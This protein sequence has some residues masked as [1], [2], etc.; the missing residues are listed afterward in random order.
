VLDTRNYFLYK[1]L[2]GAIL[3]FLVARSF[4]SKVAA[5]PV[6]AQS[7]DTLAGTML[8]GRV[9]GADGKPLEGV[10]VSAR[11]VE[12]TFTTSVFTDAQGNYFFPVLDQGKYRVWVQAVGFETARVEL[13]LDPAKQ[14]R[15]NFALKTRDDLT[16]QLSGAE[17]VDALPGDT[18]EN[19]RMKEI[20][21]H[22]CGN[23]HTPSFP[24]Q[25][26]FDRAGWLKILTA[27]ETANAGVGGWAEKPRP[28]I[29][30]FK[31]ELASYLAKMRGPDPSPMQFHPLP[32]P[33][34]DA[35]RVVMTEYDIPPAETPDRLAVLDGSDWA[36]GTP[37][38]FR[39]RGTHDVTEDFDGNAW[40]TSTAPNH[41]RTYGKIDT[42]TGK[43]TN[44][45]VDFKQDWVRWSH[46]IETAPDGMI[47]ITLNGTAGTVGFKEKLDGTLGRINPQTGKIELFNAPPGMTPYTPFGG[48]VDIDGKGKVWAVTTKGALRL[49]PATRKFTDFI[50]PS[51]DNPGFATYGL[52]AD[53]QGNGWWAIITEDKIGGSDIET[54]KSRE[55]QLAPRNE[56]KEFTTQ[57]DRNFYDNGAAPNGETATPWAQTPRRMAGDHTG[58]TVW[59]NDL[60]GQDIAGVD[61]RSLKV[62]YYDLPVPYATAYALY[63]DDKHQV[64][65]TLRNADRVGKFDPE[66]GKWT[67]YQLPS[68]GLECRGIYVDDYKK[69]GN[70]WLASWRAS[71]VIRMQFRTEQ[72]L[73]AVQTKMTA[74][75]E[76]IASASVS[77]T[78]AN[79]N[80]SG[81]VTGT[82]KGE[83]LFL[84]RCSL[85]H[86]G[87]PPIFKTYAPLLHKEVVATMGE[88]AMR[89]II[90]E[91]SP[92]M[93]AWKY[94]L[95]PAD[96]DEIL[97]YLKTV[98]KEEVTHS[99]S[100]EGGN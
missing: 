86:W 59:A 63:V 47:W 24:L 95:R 22:N 33:T 37:S 43:I 66:T 3:L 85:C 29:Q 97:A 56:M 80:S 72:Q 55:V 38:D 87:V 11:D 74:T 16:V 65:T 67:V 13:N 98:T 52:A 49:D 77:F 46:D 2:L 100:G 42:K 6:P 53:S 68:R 34:G 51:V 64:W 7:A 89:K 88:D 94:S 26:R 78:Q 60:F 28:S 9:Q 76:T 75:K 79:N 15:E 21:Q 19:R 18:F 44:Y 62:K 99:P 82:I 58:S 32:R 39:N 35:A 93:P 84:Q 5:A 73:A 96:I 90:M 8:T 83:K 14:V 40:F 54:G 1:A 17:M 92:N 57:E 50:S 10:T 45:K 20:F 70:V 81:P 31:E 36:D 61:I 25:N 71:K 41:V 91:G 48:F 30:H 12:K 69:T 4:P 23:C 27:M